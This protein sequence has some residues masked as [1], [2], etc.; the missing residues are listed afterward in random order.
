MPVIWT[1]GSKQ[2][3]K[4]EVSKGKIKYPII[5]KP[6]KGSGSVG[7]HI[8]N[9]EEELLGIESDDEY[10]Y[11]PF[12]NKEEYF[13]LFDT[14]NYQSSVYVDNSKDIDKTITVF[15]NSEKG[16]SE[17]KPLDEAIEYNKKQEK[18]INVF[19]KT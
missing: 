15:M 19:N 11:Q 17:Y 16:D 7:L 10:I 3:V 2:E 4:V 18:I 12:V 8:I 6:R 5:A 14:G 13:S 1:T 9:N